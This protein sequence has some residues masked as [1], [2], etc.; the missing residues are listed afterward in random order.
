MYHISWVTF[1]GHEFK[2]AGLKRDQIAAH[3]LWSLDDNAP[4]FFT[5]GFAHKRLPCQGMRCF[6][7]H[8][9]ADEYIVPFH[10]HAGAGNGLNIVAACVKG[11]CIAAHYL[12]R[13]DIVQSLAVPNARLL[14]NIP[15]FA[16]EDKRI[17]NADTTAQRKA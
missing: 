7:L 2:L 4:V 16:V 14:R 5:C 8:T 15:I 10:Q 9:V 6:T 13:A 11:S 12:Q 17:R 1:D 3:L